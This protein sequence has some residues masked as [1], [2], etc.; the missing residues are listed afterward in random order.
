MWVWL[1]RT[2][3]LWTLCCGRTVPTAIQ[4]TTSSLL[5]KMWV[6]PVICKPM[7][8][9]LRNKNYLGRVTSS[10]RTRRSFQ[11]RTQNDLQQEARRLPYILALHIVQS[12]PAEQFRDWVYTQVFAI[13]YGALEQKKE[14][15]ATM[16]KVDK[17]F[18]QA[19]MKLVP[20]DLACIYLV[21]TTRHDGDVTIYKFWCS[22]NTKDRFTSSPH[23]R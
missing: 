20:N 9:P 10:T 11:T 2:S 15:L 19:F 12:Q 8:V 23:I 21:D 18:L 16:C 22:G 13:A 17:I 6:T 5:Y 4:S 14:W 7:R 1:F 3:G